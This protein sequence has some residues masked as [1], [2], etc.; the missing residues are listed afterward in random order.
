MPLSYVQICFSESNKKQTQ[1]KPHKKTPT[2][3]TSKPPALQHQDH[4]PSLG[5]WAFTSF[6]RITPNSFLTT[7]SIFF[8]SRAMN[9]S[10][11]ALKHTETTQQLPTAASKHRE[12]LQGEYGQPLVQKSTTVSMNQ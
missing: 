8:P 11:P 1:K 9:W 10:Y 12:V 3:Q 4:K 2:K 5:M 7:L 6:Q